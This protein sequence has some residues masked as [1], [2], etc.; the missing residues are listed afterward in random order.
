MLEETERRLITSS[1]TSNEDNYA[2]VKTSAVGAAE[3]AEKAPT[4]RRAVWILT[5]INVFFRVVVLELDC[6]KAMISGKLTAYISSM[7]VW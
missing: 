6:L 7:N 5:K 4:M 1:L 3:E 2:S